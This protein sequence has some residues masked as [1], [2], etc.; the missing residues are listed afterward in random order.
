LCDT[1]YL[2]P[3]IFS[4]C[5]ADRFFATFENRWLYYTRYLLP[6]SQSLHC[7]KIF[8]SV[9]EPLVVLYPLLTASNSVHSLLTDFSFHWRTAGCILPATYRRQFS[10]F[11]ADKF[12]ITL[13]NRWLYT[14]YLPPAIQF[15]FIADRFLFRWRTAGCAIPAT[16]RGNS[17]SSLPTDFISLENRWLYTCYL[18]LTTAGCNVYPLLTAEIQSLHCWQV[19]RSVWRTA[20]CIIPST[21]RRQFSSPS[22]LTDFSLRSRTAG[23]IP[24]TYRR[25]FSPRH[26]WQ[27]FRSVGEPLVVRYPLLTAAIQS[28]HCWQ[29]FRS[30]EEPLVVCSLLT[31]GNSVPSLLTDFLFRWRTAGCIIPATYGRQFS[32][33]SLLTDFRSVGEPLVV[34]YPLPAVHPYIVQSLLIHYH[35]HVIHVIF[36][37]ILYT[38]KCAVVGK[39]NNLSFFLSFFLSYLRPAIFSPFIADRFFVPLENRWLYNVYLLVLLT[40]AI[41]SLHCWRIFRSVGEPLVE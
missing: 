41:L 7:W 19:F 15:P 10:P 13:E 12:F 17:V 29:I 25:Q 23:C 24:A 6:A 36:S 27:I 33:P 38:F 26:C 14:R 37:L 5:I 9:G 40:A 21:Y 34:L 22:L 1:R 20:G 11:I 8:R 28:L 4:P 31:A 32:V 39:I 16:Y 3:A 2:P 18:P 35:I 30:V